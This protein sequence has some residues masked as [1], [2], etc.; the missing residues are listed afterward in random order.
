MHKS[1]TKFLL[2]TQKVFTI[3]FSC[4][5]FSEKGSV[6]N[7]GAAV[8][9]YVRHQVQSGNLQWDDDGENYS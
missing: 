8:V 4:I 5:P 3:C 7:L 1:V 2:S 6:W 9:E